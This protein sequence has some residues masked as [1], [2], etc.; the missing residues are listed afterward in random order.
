MGVCTH[1]QKVANYA[2]GEP[3]KQNYEE[4]SFWVKDNKKAEIYYYYGKDRKEMK[5]KF[6]AR[7]VLNGDSCFKVQLSKNYVLFIIPQGNQ[8]KVSDQNGIYK[9]VFTWKYE[10]PENGIGTFCTPCA[11]DENAAMQLIKLYYM[12]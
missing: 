12:K 2:V 9:K 3:G 6:I 10:G 5:P 8:L 11:E 4:F 1:A 7:T